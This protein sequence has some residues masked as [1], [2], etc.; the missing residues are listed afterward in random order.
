MKLPTSKSKDILVQ[1]TTDELLI[2]DLNTNKTYHLNK[3][4]TIVYRACGEQASFADLKVKHKFTDDL[5]Y[6]TLDELKANNLLEDYKSNYFKGVSRR[7]AIKRVG[8][9]SMIALPIVTGLIAP[10]AAA[11][12]SGFAPGSRNLNQSCNMDADCV[13]SAQ[14]CTSTTTGNACCVTGTRNTGGSVVSGRTGAVATS[15]AIC[16]LVPTDVC[17]AG[18]GTTYN[19]SGSCVCNP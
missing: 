15:Q 18:N 16:N 5:I 4:S 11:A 7:E 13:S 6:F 17:C 1:E 12:Q 9:A 8:L 3:T 14:Q 19:G 2:Y 10:K